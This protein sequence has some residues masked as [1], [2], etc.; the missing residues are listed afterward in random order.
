METKQ[1]RTVAFDVKSLNAEGE[2]EGYGSIFGNKDSYGDVVVR[3]A[4]NNHL[5]SVKPESIKMLWQH[6]PH[7][8]I[9]VY[10]EVKEDSTGLFVKGRLLVNDIPKA[11]EAYA[12]LK[13]QAID[14]LSIGYTINA[15]GSEYKDNINYLK[16]LKLWEISIVTFPA[17]EIATVN[18][19]KELI[20]SDV[21]KIACIK[22]F[23]RI[24]RDAGLSRK[25]ATS[26]ALHGYKGFQRDAE[27]SQSVDESADWLIA[28]IK[29][30]SEN[31][32]DYK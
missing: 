19:V 8:P 18:A 1:L 32:K 14:G 23:E 10:S 4:F 6:N 12:L 9:G 26:V 7:E 13:A 27:D 28:K 31:L 16:N 2:F 15:N 5:S 20:F 24:L 3:G 22:D 30:L 17:N 21:S 25:L 29:Q 11:R